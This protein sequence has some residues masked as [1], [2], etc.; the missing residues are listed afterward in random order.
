MLQLIIVGAEQI[1][2]RQLLIPYRSDSAIVRAG[3]LGVA[4]WLVLTVALVPALHSVG[5][6]LV[7]IAAEL[8]VL[9]VATIE[10]RR[11]LRVSFPFR[12]FLLSCLYAVPYVLLGL[13]TLW[14]T[15]LMVP[16]LIIAAILYTA[17]ALLLE[18]KAYRT[19]ILASIKRKKGIK[20]KR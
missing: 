20:V 6:C 14:L 13:F 18:H 15:E 9:I 8:T 16:R 19:G 10:T 4:V 5:T 3:I 2:V 7:W 11:S 12:L 17:Y 1:I